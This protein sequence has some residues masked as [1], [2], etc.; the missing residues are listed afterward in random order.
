MENTVNN[1]K[2]IHLTILSLYFILYCSN[3]IANSKNILIEEQQRIK[4]QEKINNSELQIKK[5]EQFLFTNPPK[6]LKVA[7]SLVN[8]EE[9]AQKINKISIDLVNQSISLNFQSIIQHYENKKLTTPQI[10]ELVKELTEVLYS[11]GYIT[12]AIGLK[13]TNISDGHLKFIIHWGGVNNYYVNGQIPQSFKDKA[14]LSTL[15]NLNNKP[16]N[17]FDA[18]QI[19]EIT[20]NVN[21]STRLQIIASQEMSKSNINIETKRSVMPAFSI[22]F[23]NSGSENNANGRNQLTATLSVSDLIGINDSWSFSTN[24]R[25]YKNSKENSQQNYA[26][27]YSQPLGFYTLDLKLA[28]LGYEKELRG[29]NDNYKSEGKTQTASVK[30]SRILNR[31]RESILTAY[32]ELEFKKKN[33]YVVNRLI[34]DNLYSKFNIGLSHI[35]TFWNGKLHSDLNFSNGLNWFNSQHSAYLNDQLKTMQV[36]SG[37]VNWHKPFTMIRPLSYQFRAGAQYSSLGLL[38]DNQFAIGDEYTVR[39]FK[40]GIVSGDKGV[41]ISQTLTIPFYPQKSVLSVI[42]PFIGVDWGQVYQKAS[43][44]HNTLVGVALGLKMQ[45]Q[46][47]SLS[48]TYAKPLRSTEN[49]PKGNS[50]VPHFNGAIHF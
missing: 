14:M 17:I 4:N 38:S 37:S 49:Y 20:N 1:Y 24:Y 18:D 31:N 25:F 32:G 21:K 7:K 33:N 45:A 5:A 35:S 26:I 3:V 50:G 8:K 16:F 36:I 47:V 40:G 6:K 30:V 27:N 2:K 42:S 11:Q 44:Q 48:V 19:V 29:N 34:T 28:H 22:G 23:N 15:P 41:F 46:N 13:E 12:S 39:G 43:K 9:Q 10:L